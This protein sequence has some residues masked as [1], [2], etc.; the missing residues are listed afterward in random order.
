MGGRA[1]SHD[2]TLALNVAEALNTRVLA[3]VDAR[4]LLQ[5]VLGVDHAYLIAHAERTLLDD[6]SARYL[7]LAE[8]RCAG[9][10]V[11]YLIGWRE[12]YG[13]RFQV[14]PAVLIPRPETELLVD[15]AL[16]RIA[17]AGTARILDLGTGSG[18]VAL[19]LALERPGVEVVATEISSMALAT[20]HANAR[21]FRVDHV[22]L[23]HGDW[24]APVAGRKFN[25]IVSNPPYV[26]AGDAHLTQ[27]D[28]GF[29]PRSAL[30]AGP[31]G[32]NCIRHIVRES[33][34]HLQPGGWLLFEHGY[35]QGEACAALLNAAGYVG[36]F[37]ARDLAGLARVSGARVR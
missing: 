35:D 32:L 21:N 5:H 1:N 12:F 28:V 14:D 29:E 17:P 24:F 36:A 20:A 8:R 22:Q 31:D 9:E 13:R 27:S 3:P 19:T 23:L 16:Q 34:G 26:A 7:A 25:M 2:E 10:P 18:I 37:L 6:E 30:I 11:A 15:L 4:V 33:Q